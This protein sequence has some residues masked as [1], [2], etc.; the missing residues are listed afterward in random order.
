MA[1]TILFREMQ[2]KPLRCYY[3]C[4]KCQ[5]LKEKMNHP[6]CWW[7]YGVTRTFTHYYCE[8]KMLPPA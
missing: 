3:L 8:S 2:I 7:E 4:T 5:N 6:K 1:S